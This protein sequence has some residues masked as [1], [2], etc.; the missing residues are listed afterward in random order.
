M[1]KINYTNVPDKRKKVS[2]EVTKYLLNDKDKLEFFNTHRKK[3]D[4]ADCYLQCLTYYDK[5]IK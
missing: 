2:I 4:L 3:D 5:K 1:K